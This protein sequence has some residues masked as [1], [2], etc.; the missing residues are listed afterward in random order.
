[1]FKTISAVALFTMSVAAQASSY[2]SVDYQYA[3]ADTHFPG[4]ITVSVMFHESHNCHRA[5]L[6]II[7]NGYIREA[8]I[9]IDGEVFRSNGGPDHRNADGV[10]FANISKGFLSAL[11]H[12]HHAYLAT[13][14]GDLSMSLRGSA[15]AINTAWEVCEAKAGRVRGTLVAR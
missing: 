5:D 15:A 9:N 2:W 4:G 1:M 12:G 14:E 6:L 11:K 8:A 7:G 13:D 3:T 10:T